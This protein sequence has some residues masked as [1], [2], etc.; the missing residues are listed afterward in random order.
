M[1]FAERVAL[2]ILDGWGLGEDP[3]ADAIARADT[4][5][6]DRLMRQ[7]P[8]TTLCTHGLD[9]GLPDGQMGNSEV[10]HLNLGAGRI[11]YQ[12]LTRIHQM[13]G[14]GTLATHPML[15]EAL[16]AACQSGRLHL[17][18]LVSDGG[19]HSHLD[20]LLALTDYASQAGVAHTFI[21]A[22][23]DGR[24][25]DPE[26]GI[27]FVRRLEE[28]I[29][30]YDGVSI[31]SICG[32]YYAMDRDHRWER[33]RQ[34]Y[35]LMVHGMGASHDNAV[36][37]V[38][39]SYKEGVTD[40]FILPVWLNLPGG[41]D[42][43]IQD[44]DT[45]L[46]FNFRTDRCRQLVSVLSQDGLPEFGMTPLNIH[47]YTMTRYDERF[48][49]VRVI[50]E[51]EDIRHTL[52]E[53]ISTAGR[54]QLRIAETE[55]YPHVTFFFSGGRETPFPG[56]RRVM[57]PSPGVA[58]YDLQPSMSAEAVTDAALEEVSGEAPDFICL[59]FANT[60]M[61]GHTG[62]FTAA[63]E[64]AETVD[65]CLSRLVPALLANSYH[66]L[67]CAD[68]GNADRMINPDGTP[69]T[70]H[71]MNPVPLI[72]VA[73]PQ[74]DTQLNAGRLADIAPTVLALLGLDIPADMDGRVL[75]NTNLTS[76]D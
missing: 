62:V 2:L 33:I 15:Q 12:E 36:E 13:I 4:P 35:N 55:K 47:V 65:Q 45:V 66:L 44:G 7:Y 42:A 60:D 5:F 56:E 26:S 39:A 8:H 41:T 27:G 3:Q 69:H 43:C 57:I 22:F 25:C 23:T 67:I 61:V 34:A 16:A 10:G 50:L 20:H 75:L 30:N 31:A 48:H 58:T 49:K 37:A 76:C 29:A 53:V 21:H 38:R 59:N 19:V 74:P 11:V 64:A 24:D 68:H 14:A 18:G 32:R 70:A 28:H 73:Q 72:Y 40:E 52:G 1:K 46:F 6:F 54:S 17:V 51:K 71:T 9:V 63:M